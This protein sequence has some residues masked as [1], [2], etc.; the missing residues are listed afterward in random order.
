MSYISLEINKNGKNVEILLNGSIIEQSDMKG[1]IRLLINSVEG[2][3]LGYSPSTETVEKV[4]SELKH[5]K[6]P[7]RK[8]VDSKDSGK[9]SLGFKDA[10]KSW[11]KFV[12][13]RQS[14][15]IRLITA[16]QDKEEKKIEWMFW[17]QINTTAGVIAAIRDI[18]GIS[19]VLEQQVD[20]KMLW[21]HSDSPA[22]LPMSDEYLLDEKDPDKTIHGSDE[23]ENN[24][25]KQTESTLVTKRAMVCGKM[26]EWTED[27]SKIKVRYCIDQ[28][29]IVEYISKRT[30][31]E[32]I[33]Y[34]KLK[35]SEA[36]E[37]KGWTPIMVL[38]GIGKKSFNLKI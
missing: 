12:G 37:E 32:V 25:N 35:K 7:G 10:I 18:T 17:N 15:L 29:D 34:L 28:D 8:H 13:K 1:G 11:L 27:K 6:S 33:D 20:G 5:K 24:V 4:A 21:V 22:Y 23:S 9:M 31:P 16:K 30:E 2:S 3:F 38:Q 26:R 36:K 14:E 19:A